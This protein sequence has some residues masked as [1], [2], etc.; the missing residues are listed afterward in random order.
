[1]KARGVLIQRSTLG[2]DSLWEL[3]WLHVNNINPSLQCEVFPDLDSENAQ[4]KQNEI[5]GR[6]HSDVIESVEKSKLESRFNIC[7]TPHQSNIGYFSKSVQ[8]GSEDMFVIVTSRV[9][10]FRKLQMDVKRSV[11]KCV[12]DGKTVNWGKANA[13]STRAGVSQVL[14]RLTYA[15][16]LSY[17]RRLNSPIGRE[18]SA[19]NPILEFLEWST[20]NFEVGIHQNF[21]LL[22]GENI[23]TAEK[24]GF[25]FN[26]LKFYFKINEMHYDLNYS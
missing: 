10:L 19:A 3:M 24:T 25:I 8:V 26:A 18:G 15:S 17:L 14:N 21:D 23:E 13:A 16:T 7:K 9:Q 5:E 6:W 11:K 4:Q 12:D 1:M 2:E 20:E 22:V